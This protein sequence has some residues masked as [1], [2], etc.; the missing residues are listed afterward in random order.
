MLLYNIYIFYYIV[1]ILF[2]LLILTGPTISSSG[3]WLCEDVSGQRKLQ[4]VQA[5]GG[6]VQDSL[7]LSQAGGLL[8]EILKVTKLVM[9]LP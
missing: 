2:Y 3:D 9:V 6:L 8:V 1:F 5:E 7:G 4:T